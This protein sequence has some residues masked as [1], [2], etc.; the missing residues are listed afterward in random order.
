MLMRLGLPPVVFGNSRDSGRE[1]CE[2]IAEFA[3]AGSPRDASRMADFMLASIERTLE[4]ALEL[5]G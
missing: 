3:R 2:T 4:R 1:Y 5:A